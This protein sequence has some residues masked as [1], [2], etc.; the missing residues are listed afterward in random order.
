[1]AGR[2]AELPVAG[3]GVWRHRDV[4]AIH[5]PVLHPVGRWEGGLRRHPQPHH[6]DAHLDHPNQVQ[7]TTEKV[8]TSNHL[9]QAISHSC[10]S[11]LL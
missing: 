8:T 7:M 5:T 2:A 3:H 6:L 4:A 11:D 1:V 10:Y 9:Q